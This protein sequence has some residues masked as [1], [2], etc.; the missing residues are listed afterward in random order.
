[1]FLV[2]LLSLTFARRP[3][4]NREANVND[5]TLALLDVVVIIRINLYYKI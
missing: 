3:R 4:R 5:A 1:M 2:L